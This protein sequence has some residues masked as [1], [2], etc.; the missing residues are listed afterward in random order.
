MFIKL[1]FI[2]IFNILFLVPFFNLSTTFAQQPGSFYCYQNEVW[3]HGNG[4]PNTDVKIQKCGADQFC[5]LEENSERMACLNTCE[6]NEDVGDGKIQTCKGE[7]L[8][9]TNA[10]GQSSLACRFS[11]RVGVRCTDPFIQG[12]TPPPPARNTPGKPAGLGPDPANLSD[13]EKLFGRIIAISV[14]GAFI[15]MFVVLVTAGIKFLT[16]GGEPKAIASAR[17]AAVWALLG[18]LFLI[19]AWLVIQLIAAIT[20]VNAIKYFDVRVLCGKLC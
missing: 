17:D 3:Q 19:I 13:L 20:G 18:L 2:G 4:G 15:A 11:D 10:A 8:P 12:T 7:M 5:G 1:F 14:A 16:S 9:I 6:Y